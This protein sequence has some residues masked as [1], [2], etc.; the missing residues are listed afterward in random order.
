MGAREVPASRPQ[1]RH[2]IG[3][4]DD[5]TIPTAAA[6]GV[7]NVRALGT[8]LTRHNDHE[9]TLRYDEPLVEAAAPA[10]ETPS[11]S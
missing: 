1:H 5:T 11:I 3:I 7:A 4:R 10:W 8:T 9:G 2:F 6:A